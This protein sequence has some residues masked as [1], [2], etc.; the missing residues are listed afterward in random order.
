MR[1]LSVLNLGGGRLE[2]YLPKMGAQIRDFMHTCSFWVSS[3]SASLSV[4]VFSFGSRNS[5]LFLEFRI[6]FMLSNLALT[7]LPEVNKQHCKP[8]DPNASETMVHAVS[9]AVLAECNAPRLR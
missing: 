7:D 8:S 3:L 6:L 1:D 4:V 2:D 9:H 5:I